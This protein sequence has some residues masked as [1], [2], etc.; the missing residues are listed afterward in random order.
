MNRTRALLAAAF[1]AMLIGPR[2]H[3]TWSIV[4]VDTRT[5]EIAIGSATCLRNTNLLKTVPVVLVDRG[6]AAAQ[7]SVDPT[8]NN[9]VLIWGEMLAG[10]DPAAILQLLEDSDPAFQT[11][12]YG[13][14]D[15]LGRAI[16]FT[17]DEDLDFAG[18]IVGRSGSLVWAI[19]GNILTCST[20]IEDAE[21]AIL[22]EP[23]GLPEKLMAGMEA[24]RS[25]GGDGRCSC[26]SSDPT[27]GCPPD[28]FTKS[29]HVGF[30]V[31]TRRGD[32]DGTC[33][34]AGCATGTYYMR[35]NFRGDTADPDP[36]IALREMFDAF[37]L[38][39]VGRADAVESG[40]MLSPCALPPDGSSTATMTIELRDWQGNPA[41]GVTNVSV[42]HDVGSAGVSSIGPVADLGGSVYGVTLTAGSMGGQ[43]ILAVQVTDDAGSRY[44]IPSAHLVSQDLQY[45]LNGDFSLDTGDLAVLL[46]HFGMPDGA[47][48]ND[49]DLDLD[50]DVDLSD[51]STL[52]LNFA[53][54]CAP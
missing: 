11:R 47:Q 31:G 52:L 19:Q 45:D 12:Q 54:P 38:G 44:L 30:M 51:L 6:A 42:V 49:G 9:R 14:V 41:A 28:G 27:C 34:S 53:E 20:V 17:G 35:L 29:A 22:T 2:A 40:V 7:A 33:S 48:F 10:S 37:R 24:A 16:S 50:G 32:V 46:A 13:I 3:A 26:S 36:V 5:R 15:V 1:A 18:S 43:D 8:G 25:W 4:L 39:L 21:I 23:G